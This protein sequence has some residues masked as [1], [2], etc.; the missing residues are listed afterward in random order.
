MLERS[1]AANEEEPEDPDAP[2]YLLVFRLGR[3]TLEIFLFAQDQ[4]VTID[5]FLFSDG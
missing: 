2:R 3:R 4:L 1:A 5:S